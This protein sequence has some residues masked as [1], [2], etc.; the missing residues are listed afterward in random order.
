M[1]IQGMRLR[2]VCRIRLSSS[3][4][5]VDMMRNRT[6][7]KNMQ[8]E[9]QN[10]D[11]IGE[12]YIKQDIR[13]RYRSARN[14]FRLL[15]I[16]MVWANGCH[17]GR[18]GKTRKRSILS[19]HGR[20][21]ACKASCRRPMPK[22]AIFDTD[23]TVVLTCPVGSSSRLVCRRIQDQIRKAGWALCPMYVWAVVEIWFQS[24]RY[25]LYPYPFRCVCVCEKSS[26]WSTHSKFQWPTISL[27][28]WQ[29]SFPILMPWK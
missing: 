3:R 28:A 2:W 7:C 29:Q 25:L 24:H 19:V 15:S 13:H 17:L 16:Q 8:W 9:T 23:W 5:R 1:E 12:M 21:T 6:R 22:K 27:Y 20:L 18:T 10:S 14:R 11:Y 26:S 4:D